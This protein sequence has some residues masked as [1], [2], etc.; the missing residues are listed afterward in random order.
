MRPTNS[1]YFEIVCDVTSLPDVAQ[2]RLTLYDVPEAIPEM[3]K[4]SSVS[5]FRLLFASEKAIFTPPAVHRFAPFDTTGGD[6]HSATCV[7]VVLNSCTL[8]VPSGQ[9][10]EH[11]PEMPLGLKMNVPGIVVS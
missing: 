10:G 1:V 3:V 5:I 7:L 9:F 8:N 11:P 2:M 6:P 4:K